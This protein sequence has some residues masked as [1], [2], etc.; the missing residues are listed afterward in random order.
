M[1]AL[2]PQQLNRSHSL[3][4]TLISPLKQAEAFGR[5]LLKKKTCPKYPVACTYS[6]YN[7]A[8]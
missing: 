4:S 5:D 2:R 6:L 8:Q 7:N 1:T 3:G